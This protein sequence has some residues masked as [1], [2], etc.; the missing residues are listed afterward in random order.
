MDPQ[1]V[2]DEVLDEERGNGTPEEV[3]VARA[4]A[5]AERARLGSPHPKEAKFWVSEEGPPPRERTAVETDVSS[6]PVTEEDVAKVPD[7]PAPSSSADQA[8]APGTAERP[9]ARPRD[10]AAE[11]ATAEEAARRP[12]AQL[13]QAEEH[14]DDDFALQ[15]QWETAQRISERERIMAEQRAEVNDLIDT[16]VPMVAAAGTTRGP[17]PLAI[18]LYVV[19][20]VAAALIFIFGFSNGGTSEPTA[21]EGGSST[22]NTL[23]DVTVSASNIQFDTS[24][25]TV[26]AGKQVTIHFDNKDASSVQHDIAVYQTEAA[27]QVIYDGKTIP[28]GSSIDYTFKTPAKPGTYFF[29]CDVH[30]TSMM[31]KFVVK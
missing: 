25:I 21:A 15:G 4:E 29:R 1:H 20:P 19:I 9:A 6:Q 26:A 27:K 22:Q 8:M 30:P 23:T 16:G 18:A 11:P 3:A 17:S 12:S 5:A 2:Y 31:G 7:K 24:T 14:A 13:H 10:E 28:G